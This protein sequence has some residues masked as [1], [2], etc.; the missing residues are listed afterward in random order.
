MSSFTIAKGGQYYLI[1]EYGNQSSIWHMKHKSISAIQK[2]LK[3]QKAKKS[4]LPRIL[5]MVLHCG[6]ADLASK[7]LGNFKDLSW[8]LTGTPKSSPLG[9]GLTPRRCL[10]CPTYASGKIKKNKYNSATTSLKKKLSETK[11]CKSETHS[12]IG[13]LRISGSFPSSLRVLIH[14]FDDWILREGHNNQNL[15]IC[16]TQSIKK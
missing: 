11:F 4:N 1:F 12:V 9:V 6:Q 15:V 10:N 8:V 16:A 13:K 14:F 2:S 3:L 7:L 5:L